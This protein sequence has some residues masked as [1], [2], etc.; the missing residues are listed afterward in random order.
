MKQTLF[1]LMAI[2]FRIPLFAQAD[3]SDAMLFGDV[4]VK[5]TNEHIPYASIYVKGSSIGTASDETGHFKLAHLPEGKQTIV[6]QFVGYKPQELEVTM[7]RGKG[8][9]LYFEL[10]EDLFN[11]EQV[12]VT[13]TR[14][15]H[16]VKSV[17]VRTEVVTSQELRNKNA[18]NV[19]EALEGVPGIPHPSPW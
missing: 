16:Y 3:A 17:P 9:T 5:G 18:W 4:R 11:L 14:T 2:L 6:A 12:V 7:E 15:Q 10:E 19:F 8:K 1:L 13:G